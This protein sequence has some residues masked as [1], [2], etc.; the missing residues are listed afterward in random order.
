MV[1]GKKQIHSMMNCMVFLSCWLVTRARV[2]ATEC[3]SEEDM[4]VSLL[5][6]SVPKLR[7]K[8]N[9]KVD[10]VIGVGPPK[11]G[12][13]SLRRALDI[14]GRKAA[15]GNTMFSSAFD[16]VWDDVYN[17]DNV[18]AINKILQA[19]YDA[20]AGDSPWCFMYE[21]LMRMKPNYKVIMSVHPRGP[22]GWVESTHTWN[23]FHVKG[24]YDPGGWSTPPGFGNRNITDFPPERVNEN[25]YASKLDCFI[26]ETH[27]QSWRDR[28]KQGYLAHY[29][30]V[31]RTVP[32]ERLLEFNVSDGWAPL[33]SFLGLPVP[34]VTFP[35]VNDRTNGHP[36]KHH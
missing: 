19:G 15:H 23:E 13:S 25:N 20:T 32:R 1:L 6:H 5:Q 2:I 26:N 3:G 35:D 9:S 27:N 16:P 10:F 29:D 33:C 17:G 36:G 18:P 7:S 11:T 24:V 30:T 4:G 22:D 31:R 14:L 21:D 8:A 28:C 12:T 34:N